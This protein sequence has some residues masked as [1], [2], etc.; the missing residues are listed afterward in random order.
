MPGFVPTRCL[1]ILTKHGDFVIFRPYKKTSLIC[2]FEID[3]KPIR[4]RT[5]VN[6]LAGSSFRPSSQSVEGTNPNK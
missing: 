5:G 2:K 4:E 6:Y 1:L 3:G